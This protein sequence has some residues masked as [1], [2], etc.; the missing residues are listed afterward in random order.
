M[1]LQAAQP[2][3]PLFAPP[4]LSSWPA[5]PAPRASRSSSMCARSVASRRRSGEPS[6]S[7]AA[8]PPLP[9]GC[10]R[11]STLKPPARTI[12]PAAAF[13]PSRSGQCKACSAWNSLE[14]VTVAPAGEAG[15]GGGARAAARFAAGKT[16]GSFSDDGPGGGGSGGGGPRPLRRTSWVQEVEGGQG[17]G[18]ELACHA[19]VALR[20]RL[21]TARLSCIWRAPS[22]PTCRPASP[23]LLLSP[24]PFV[25]PNLSRLQ[26]RS[27]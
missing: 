13:V 5:L 12:E 27:G 2:H 8:F 22:L 19:P 4:A 1:R 15:G 23:R 9:P 14:K 18:Q 26:P 3:A 6:R 7:R 25:L 17:A 10:R 11:R 21:V 16:A 24:P 20:G